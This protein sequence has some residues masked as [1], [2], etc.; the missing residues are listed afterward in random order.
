M[1]SF[2][3]RRKYRLKFSQGARGKPRERAYRS[4]GDADT[5]L[6][7]DA[8]REGEPAALREVLPGEDC[9]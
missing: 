6:L 1:F 5:D 4:G 2:L 9:G 3:R 7:V 8:S